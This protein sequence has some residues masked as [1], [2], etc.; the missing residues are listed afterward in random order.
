MDV[1]EFKA[2]IAR[3]DA[4]MQEDWGNENHYF[5]RPFYCDQ[6]ARNSISIMQAFEDVCPDVTFVKH[7]YIHID[8][9]IIPMEYAK[10]CVD[11][12]YDQ[13]ARKL[14]ARKGFKI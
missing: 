12:G 2:I 10:S 5:T 4:I 8:D 3:N 1:E 6:G 13:R 14:A 7:P 9:M 11:L